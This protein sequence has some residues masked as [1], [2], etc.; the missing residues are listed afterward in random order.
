MI[1]VSIF[2]IFSFFQ[3]KANDFEGSSDVAAPELRIPLDDIKCMCKLPMKEFIK[4]GKNQN[5]SF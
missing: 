1:R 4:L 2:I 5:F 3:N